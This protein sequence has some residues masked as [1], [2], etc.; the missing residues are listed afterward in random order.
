MMSISSV[1]SYFAVP[2]LVN[3]LRKLST[4][5]AIHGS[6]IQTFEESDGVDMLCPSDTVTMRRCACERETDANGECIHPLPGPAIIG[7]IANNGLRPF[8]GRTIEMWVMQAKEQK[9]VYIR[10][11]A[12]R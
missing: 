9:F 8:H 6:Q 11:E 4:H 3:T 1:R 7:K 5:L 10:K 2:P 12:V